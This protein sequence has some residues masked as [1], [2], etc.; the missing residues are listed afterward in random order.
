MCGS[1]YK[2]VVRLEDISTR[3]EIFAPF[4]KRLGIKSV[5]YPG[6]HTHLSD[7]K[8]EKENGGSGHGVANIKTA[9]GEYV[10][11]WVCVCARAC[12]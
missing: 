8:E 6:P 4:F 11:V 7:K 2:H 9:S 1:N 10:H 12:V 3:P 5:P